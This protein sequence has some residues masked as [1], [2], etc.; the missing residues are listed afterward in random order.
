MAP[1]L[2]HL[3][4]LPCSR[5]VCVRSCH[6]LAVTLLYRMAFITRP[7]AYAYMLDNH[8]ACPACIAAIALALPSGVLAPVDSPP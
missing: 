3:H 4:L 1:I 7:H 5:N 6:T 2:A 8:L